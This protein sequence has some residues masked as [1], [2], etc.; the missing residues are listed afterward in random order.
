[1]TA[2]RRQALARLG[3]ATAVAYAAPTILHLDRSAKAQI[4][5]SCENPPGGGPPDPSCNGLNPLSGGSEATGGGETP[6]PQ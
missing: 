2:S 5:P 3:F 1:M 4:L 6:P